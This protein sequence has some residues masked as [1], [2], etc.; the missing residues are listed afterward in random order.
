MDFSLPITQVAPLIPQSGEMVLLDKILAFGED[1][2]QAE[3]EIRPDHIL[4][5]AGKLATFS[6]IEIMAQGVAAW[7]GIQAR[8]RNEPV[9]LGY[10]LGTRKLQLYQEEIAVGSQIIIDVK[11][12]IQ[13]V[14]GFGVFDCKLIDKA[15]EQVLLEG[16]LNVFSP[17]DGK[18]QKEG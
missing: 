5:N 14:T 6:G 15:T 13:D 16:A 9:R 12:S 1:Y 4:I 2:L 11:M 17:K 7:A 8:Q 10:L 18:I 3:A